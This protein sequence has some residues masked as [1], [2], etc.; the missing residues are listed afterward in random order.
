[1]R[2]RT[3]SKLEQKFSD[4]I[5]DREGHGR[6]TKLGPGMANYLPEKL[7]AFFFSPARKY[8]EGGNGSSSPRLLSCQV[9]PMEINSKLKLRDTAG[10]MPASCVGTADESMVVLPHGP[11]LVRGGELTLALLTL[12]GREGCL[13]PYGNSPG[14]RSGMDHRQWLWIVQGE[15]RL[16]SILMIF[17]PAVFG[18][19]DRFPL[20]SLRS[21]E[22]SRNGEC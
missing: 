20:I 3:A 19:C 17:F 6:R 1:M 8:T 10:Q 14:E 13:Q 22:L 7:C 16:Y 2:L 15:G 18:S 11:R 5:N 4:D 12:W 9:W 21:K